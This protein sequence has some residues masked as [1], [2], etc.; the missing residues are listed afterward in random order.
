MT[1][2][3]GK[4]GFTVDQGRANELPACDCCGHPTR[5]VRGFVFKEGTARA[6]YLV[7]WKPGSAHDAELAV[8]VG[9]WCDADAT[10]RRTIAL[11]LRQV[12]TGLAFM[13]VDADPKR[14]DDSIELGLSMSSSEVTRSELA[15]EVYEI[16][17]AVADGDARLAGWNL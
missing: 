1:F 4:L 8:I 7:R 15:G 14:W 9:G 2:D 6:V 12:E 13:V 10:P 17:D 3:H 11:R 16:L 5:I